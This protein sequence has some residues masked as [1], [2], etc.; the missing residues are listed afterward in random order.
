MWRERGPFSWP[1]E[2][3]PHP[4]DRLFGRNG[5]WRAYLAQ[6]RLGPGPQWRSRIP[7]LG[8]RRWRPAGSTGCHTQS[9]TGLGRRS[10]RG[11]GWWC[12]HRPAAC[13]HRSRLQ[14][15]QGAQRSAWGWPCTRQELLGRRGGAGV[16]GSLETQAGYARCREKVGPSLTPCFQDSACC[17]PACPCQG[18]LVRGQFAAGGSRPPWGCQEEQGLRASGV[19][20]RQTGARGTNFKSPRVSLVAPRR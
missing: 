3:S 5:G 2:W 17:S 18:G 16:T 8:R 15:P 11:P 14:G 13:H 19:K 1:R 6:R 10:P 20:S 4:W 12:P 9:P 7:G